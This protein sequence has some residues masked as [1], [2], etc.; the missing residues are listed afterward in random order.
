MFSLELVYTLV[1]VCKFCQNYKNGFCTL[2]MA[3]FVSVFE[4]LKLLNGCEFGYQILALI[5]WVYLGG[6]NEFCW[7]ICTCIYYFLTF[8]KMVFTLCFGRVLTTYMSDCIFWMVGSLHTKFWCVFIGYIRLLPLHS[9]GILVYLWI[10]FRTIWWE[11]TLVGYT[12]L[13]VHII[14]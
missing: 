14:S 9:Y 6:L 5:Y 4:G 8:T 12:F 13:P 3:R 1:Y 2:V 7:E 11:T 10:L